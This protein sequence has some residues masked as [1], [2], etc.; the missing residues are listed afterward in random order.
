MTELA[1]ARYWCGYA[2]ERIS[3]RDCNILYSAIEDVH[4]ECGDV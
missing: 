3:I 1:A 4:L 2:G